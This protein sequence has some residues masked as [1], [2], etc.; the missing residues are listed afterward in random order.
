MTTKEHMTNKELV[1]R[2]IMEYIEREYETIT[3]YGS[4]DTLNEYQR[5]EIGAF[6][7]I[8]CMYDDLMRDY[9]EEASNND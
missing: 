5:G 8:L 7:T 9:G 2:G 3:G 4:Y 6:A 1:L